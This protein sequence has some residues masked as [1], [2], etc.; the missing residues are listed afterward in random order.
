MTRCKN[1]FHKVSFN[2]GNSKREKENFKGISS[3]GSSQ[4]V[5]GGNSCNSRCGF[6]LVNIPYS[7]KREIFSISDQSE[8][9]GCLL[10]KNPH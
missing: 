10:V 1:S 8:S 7:T 2:N 3:R 5:G 9:M 6:L 4:P